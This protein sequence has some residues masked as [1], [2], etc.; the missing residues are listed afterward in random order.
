MGVRW[1]SGLQGEDVH[2]PGFKLEDSADLRHSVVPAA[3]VRPVGVEDFEQWDALVQRS[4]QGTLFH[5][6]LFLDA[7]AMPYQLLGLFRQGE[8]QAGFVTGTRGRTAC[9]P[10][11]IL[12]P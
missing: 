3:S 4:P 6:R 2:G 10:D 5:S 1:I 8:L 12:A 9:H 11:L 7:L